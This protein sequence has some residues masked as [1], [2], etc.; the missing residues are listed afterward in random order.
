MKKG[1]FDIKA[2]NRRKKIRAFLQGITLIII[3]I[4]I[5]RA[6]FSFRTYAA[7]D[8]LNIPASS[9]KGFITVSYSGI[10]RTGTNSIISA[11]ILNKQLGALKKNGYVTINQQDIIDYYQGIKKL[12]EKSLFLIFEDGR[13]DTAIFAQKLMEKYNYKGTI[14]SYG[15]NI[16]GKDSK[17]LKGSDLNELEKSTFWET[18]TNGWRLSY[19]NVFDD[20]GKYFGVLS[21]T[22]FSKVTT[23]V[24]RD[25]N[26]YLMDFI[27]DEYR[28]PMES[29]ADLQER[30]NS[31]Y[32]KIRNVYGKET[33]KVPALY[34]LMHS[35][36]GSFGTNEKAS[37]INEK[38]I[39]DMFLMNF[40][41]EGTALNSR[42]D[43]I[44]NLT[45]IQ[46]KPYWTVNHLLMKIYEDTFEKVEFEVGDTEKAAG[47]ELM[48]GAAQYY[49]D[50]IALTSM[51][52]GQG[53]L[54]V[55]NEEPYDKIHIAVN[56]QG[57]TEGSQGLYFQRG[58]SEE[59]ILVEVAN[60]H[61]RI[62]DGENEFFNED[63]GS[64]YEMNSS[65][66]HL[67]I[68]LDNEK[69]KVLL[70]GKPVIEELDRGFARIEK[71]Y[72]HSYSEGYDSIY[73][74]I[75][76]NLVID[77]QAGKVIIDNNL[78]GLE[79]LENHV[80]NAFNRT[81]NWFIKNF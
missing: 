46:P 45:R 52:K 49:G 44:Y 27:R 18:G 13:R 8:K 60:N 12:P 69:L 15:N 4:I 68:Y 20:E 78:K 39:K 75:F 28:I 42:D 35:N 22:E 50:T 23:E 31:D 36:T 29:Y 21:P 33:G 25:Y 80:K 63:I 66:K 56:L 30:I 6:L 64:Y 61:L 51:P 77:D 7:Y 59:G 16:T 17:F 81:V 55:K 37:L 34:C 19:I 11:D 10:D 58:D 24:N 67:D 32:E 48:E 3:A 57:N 47:F 76:K 70:E 71:I 74:G 43:S 9:E 53:R 14:L 54:R 62:T 73:D 79:K 5:I 38:S 65:V 41:R 72:L 1:S 2:K 40:N 26:H